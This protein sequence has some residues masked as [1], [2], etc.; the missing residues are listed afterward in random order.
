MTKRIV[1]GNAINMNNYDNGKFKT[2]Y[3]P[4]FVGNKSVF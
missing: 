2:W 4:D 3:I 1:R